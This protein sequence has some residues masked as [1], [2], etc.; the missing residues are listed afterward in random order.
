MKKMRSLRR[1]RLG[2][3]AIACAGLALVSTSCGSSDESPA[4]SNNLTLTTGDFDIPAGDSFTCFYTDQFTPSDREMGIVGATSRQQAGGHHITAYYTDLAR[5]AQHHA[6]SEQEMIQWHMVAGADEL[7]ATES[8]KIEM[9]PGFAYRLP[10][11]KQIVLQVHYINTTGKQ[12]TVND[13][14][15][16]DLVSATTVKTWANQWRSSSEDWSVPAKG[17]ATATKICSFKNDLNA[18]LLLGHM[19]ERGK[20]F[21]LERL[22]DAGNPVEV[23]YETDWLA[24]Y[25]SHPPI[26]KWDGDKPLVIKKGTKF[27]QTCQWQNET[28]SELIFPREMCVFFGFYFPDA[29]ELDCE[30]VPG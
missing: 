18:I 5:P 20:H 10:P 14:V 17:T 26:K 4:A 13:S 27:R 12:R 30:K 25:V 3:T 22:D 11:G 23:L 1:V 8:S 9:P 28:D 21:K 2:L 16:L 29:G 19:H 6:C 7:G 24:S 15:T